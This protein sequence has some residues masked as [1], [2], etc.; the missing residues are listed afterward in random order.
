[1]ESLGGLFLTLFLLIWMLNDFCNYKKYSK[2]KNVKIFV[3]NIFV[4][5]T[6]YIFY[7][8][9]YAINFM[10]SI[11]IINSPFKLITVTLLIATSIYI[12]MTWAYKE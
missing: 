1:M 2:K 7:F 5:I 11:I 12:F 9:S 10:N 3:K 6:M 8:N 4:I